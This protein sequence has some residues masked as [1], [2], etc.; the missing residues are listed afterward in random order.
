[1]SNIRPIGNRLLVKVSKKNQTSS[2]GIILS[3]KTEEDKARGVVM[4]L[5]QGFGDEKSLLSEVK[6]GDTVI[7]GS[8]S[9]QE[10]EDDKDPDNTYKILK[11]TDIVAVID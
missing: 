6:I 2:S 10:F 3:T 4:A 7:F 5:G 8:Y 1:M 11:I 9:G